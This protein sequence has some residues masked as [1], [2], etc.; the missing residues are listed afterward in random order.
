MIERL[1]SKALRQRFPAGERTVLPDFALP[2]HRVGDA[3]EGVQRA[4]VLQ[5]LQPPP[6]HGRGR[7]HR[8]IGCGKRG[9]DLDAATRELG[10]Q[11]QMQRAV[12]VGIKDRGDGAHAPGRYGKPSRSKAGV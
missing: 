9:R 4:Q 5:S 11:R 10:R 12:R 1:I 3:A 2:R 8:L 7:G 6:H